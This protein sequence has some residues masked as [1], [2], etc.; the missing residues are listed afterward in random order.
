MGTEASNSTPAQRNFAGQQKWA[1]LNK[2]L[3]MYQ[4]ACATGT[5]Q[6]PCIQLV[7]VVHR[8]PAWNVQIGTSAAPT[9]RSAVL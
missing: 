1:V 2:K 4:L 9:L 3:D 7:D 5:L 8:K 6:L